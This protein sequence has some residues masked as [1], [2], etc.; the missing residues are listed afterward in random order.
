MERTAR[1]AAWLVWL[2]SSALALTGC[3]NLQQAPLVYA[4]KTSVGIDMSGSSTEVPGVSLALGF[5]QVDAAYVPVAVAR[6]CDAGKANCSDAGYSLQLITGT[7]MSDTTPALNEEIQKMKT[8]LVQYEIAL[9]EMQGWKARR[10][11]LDAEVAELTTSLQML[12]AKQKAERPVTPARP[13]SDV[14]ATG[15]G[16][17]GAGVAAAEESLTPKEG[18]QL[19]ELPDELQKKTRERDGADAELK[20]AESRVSALRPQA[21]AARRQL[22]KID[23]KDAYSVYGRFEG[24]TRVEAGFGQIGLGKIFSTG[25]ASQH[26]SQGLG[27]YYRYLGVAACFDAANKLAASLGDKKDELLQELAKRCGSEYGADR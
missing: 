22:E 2:G 20:Q 16:V 1:S 13:A 11:I 5:K 18:T 27:G 7:S 26:L 10:R 8:Q 19:K 9:G 21:E 15:G 14:E 12:Q 17:E 6:K 3:G 25:V 24:Q 23:R 4:S